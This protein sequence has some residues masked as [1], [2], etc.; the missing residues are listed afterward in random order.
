[1]SMPRKQ[2]KKYILQLY[3]LYEVVLSTGT[4]K[5][6]YEKLHY[7]QILSDIIVSSDFASELHLY[8]SFEVEPQKL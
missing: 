3:Y 6:Y 8:M 5:V 2:P 1:M 4:V 7:G